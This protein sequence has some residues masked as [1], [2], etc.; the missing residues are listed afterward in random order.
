MCEYCGKFE[1]KKEDFIKV[2]K[3]YVC[4]DC[5]HKTQKE[6]AEEVQ[7]AI[8]C[9]YNIMTMRK[10]YDPD[11]DSCYGWDGPAFGPYGNYGKNPKQ[12]S[13]PFG[14]VP[15]DILLTQGY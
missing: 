1:L 8:Q 11:S 2:G 12:N 3:F 14:M 15:I 13:F 6:I 5:K 9:E 7:K 4:S 10:D